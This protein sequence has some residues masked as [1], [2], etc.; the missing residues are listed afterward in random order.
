MHQTPDLTSADPTHRPSSDASGVPDLTLYRTV[1]AALREA[2]HRLARAVADAGPARAARRGALARYWEGYAGEILAHHTIED[3]FFFPA[4]VERVPGARALI[5]RTDADHAHL[6]EL[7]AH[8]SVDVAILARGGVAPHLPA[9]LDELAGHMD[10]HLGF[11]DD[12]ILPLFE[13]HFAA[14]EY[15]ALDQEAVKSLGLGKQAAFTVP[16]LLRAVPAER[17]AVVLAEAPAPLRV[18]YRL[19]RAR[20][21]RL[22]EAALGPATT[23]VEA[24]P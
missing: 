1:H 8:I 12:E 23:L 14:D 10:R 3:E 19:T 5:Q 4:L 24:T 2:A 13:Q 20:H 17:R 16:F 7:M 11:E 9:L 18:L 6:D 21:E 22:T 15:D